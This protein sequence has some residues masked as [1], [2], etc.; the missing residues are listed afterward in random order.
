MYH[1]HSVLLFISI[2]IHNPLAEVFFWKRKHLCAG[3]VAQFE[4]YWLN[5][6]VLWFIFFPLLS[7]DAFVGECSSMQCWLL[8][9][10]SAILQHLKKLTFVLLHDLGLLESKFAISNVMQQKRW[11]V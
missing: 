1:N 4:A 6:Y 11:I 8:L 10:S 3:F 9:E 5:L 2:Y 7:S